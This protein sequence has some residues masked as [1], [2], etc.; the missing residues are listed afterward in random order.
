MS[1]SLNYS[2]KNF[3]IVDDQRPFQLMLKGILVNL[4]IRQIHLVTTGEAAVQACKSKD[5]DFVLID[6]NLGGHRK[7]GRQ[8][9]EE[10]KQKKL[11][12]PACV[13]VM[14]TGE[15]HRPMVL[16]AIELQPDDYVMKPFSQNVLKLRLDKAYK[17]RQALRFVF[18]AMHKGDIGRAITECKT[19]I[20]DDSRYK[21]VCNNL[22]AELLCAAGKFEQAEY[23][24]EKLLA[25]KPYTWGQ[26]QLS[27]TYLH[28]KRYP[29]AAK[30]AHQVMLQSPLI[31]D[32]YDLS[33]QALVGMERLPNALEMAI[34]AVELSPFSIERQYR[35]CDIA[36]KNGMY[37]IVK[38]A[39]IAIL[40][41]SRKSVYQD[42]VHFFNYIRA[43]ITAA[44]HAEDKHERNKLKQEASLALQR[45]RHDDIKELKLHYNLFEDLCRA[46]IEVLDN[47]LLTAKKQFY[48]L[49]NKIKESEQAFIPNEL[50]FDAVS[51]MYNIGEF[52]TAEQILQSP[53]YESSDNQFVKDSLEHLK[54]LHQEKRKTFTEL[55]RE[56]IYAYKEGDYRLAVQRFDDALKSAPMNTGG[57]LNLI[58]AIIQL[59]TKTEKYPEDLITRLKKAFHTLQ[60]V[61]LPQVQQQRY[62]ELYEQYQ[63]LM[64]DKDGKQRKK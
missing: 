35:L 37:D 17:K 41:M 24:L 51:I 63:K 18:S 30:L 6:Y 21:N 47:K 22:L 31:I 46:Q 7:N 48:E 60:G 26:I 59:L 19:L 64:T 15:S 16:G 20:A 44:Q 12:K 14:V 33:A 38:D 49:H 27:R 10:L 52:E 32:A 34:K 13:T 54:T 4:G 8:L 43:T 45:G 25:I 61:C 56:G 11:L 29:L 50:A 53:D 39:C 5:F 23:L 1:A 62:E 57:S 3:L 42:P 40:E 55:N 28:Q 2:D 36:R 9:I 58:L